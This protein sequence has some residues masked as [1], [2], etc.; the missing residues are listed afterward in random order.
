MNYADH[1]YRLGSAIRETVSQAQDTLCGLQLGSVARR[2]RDYY[3]P[4]GPNYPQSLGE[5]CISMFEKEVLVTQDF[6]DWFGVDRKPTL[7]SKYVVYQFKDKLLTCSRRD[8]QELRTLMYHKHKVAKGEHP[9]CGD[10]KQERSYNAKRERLYRLIDLVRSALPPRKTND[11]Y[12]KNTDRMGHRRL[13]Q[14]PFFRPASPGNI[15]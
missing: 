3:N 10:P 15:R 13:F 8:I 6:S 4:P 5:L 2:L 9:Q 14:V 1:Y 12:T 11:K 7:D